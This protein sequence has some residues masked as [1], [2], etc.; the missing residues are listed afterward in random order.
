M[1]NNGGWFK[2][3]SDVNASNKVVSDVMDSPNHSDQNSNIAKV[4]LKCYLQRFY[5]KLP[6]IGS[7][8]N[9]FRT[10]LKRAEHNGYPNARTVMTFCDK[11][12][13]IK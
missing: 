1:E 5:L 10:A 12:T 3:S 13:L 9:W 8:S 7:A 11:K 6:Y 2:K 4:A